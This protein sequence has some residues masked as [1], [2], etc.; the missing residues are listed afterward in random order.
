M[1]L[2]VEDT[3]HLRISMWISL[4]HRSYLFDRMYCAWTLD[5]EFPDTLVGLDVG[6]GIRVLP[7]IED[8]SREVGVSKHLTPV[9][10]GTFSFC[11]TPRNVLIFR[12]SVAAEGGYAKLVLSAVVLDATSSKDCIP[13]IDVL[14]RSAIDA[15]RT[16]R[17]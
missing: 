16:P 4:P 14:K 11:R 12:C 3:K 17:R 15:A 5:A 6:A 2:H 10:A 13:P 7:I 9:A 1:E 8:D